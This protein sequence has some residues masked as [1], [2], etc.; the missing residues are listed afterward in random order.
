MAGVG[1]GPWARELVLC[2]GGVSGVLALTRGLEIGQM[3]GRG[4]VAGGCGGCWEA[5]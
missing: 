4:G 2:E 1:D 5:T 3:E